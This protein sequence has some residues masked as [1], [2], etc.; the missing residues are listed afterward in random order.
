MKDGD[1]RI[2]LLTAGTSPAFMDLRREAER[3]PSVVCPDNIR[4][5][6]DLL[7]AVGDM[8][9]DIILAELEL[10][11]LDA[12]RFMEL[13][14]CTDRTVIYSSG[15][16]DFAEAMVRSSGAKAFFSGKASP[17]DVMGY[18]TGEGSPDKR[19]SLDAVSDMLLSLGMM[20]HLKGYRYVR[21]AILLAS[22]R[23]HIIGELNSSIYP[24]VAEEFGTT[25]MRAERS[26]RHAI[27]LTWEKGNLDVINELFGYTVSSEKGKPT[28]AEFIAMLADRLAGRRARDTVFVP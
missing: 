7:S 13:S 3:H 17:A 11:G 14:G 21:R 8:K 25:V 24:A 15:H 20:P 10:P 19:E 12:L 28:N 1:G 9:P 22:G 6:R 26:I 5:G 27:E 4:D 18:I 2:F 16:S 23:Q